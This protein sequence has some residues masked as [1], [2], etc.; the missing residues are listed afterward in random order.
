MENDI[1]LIGE[2]GYDITLSNIIEKVN[3]SD[4]SKPLNIY[5]HSMGGSVYE[6]L[7]IYSYFKSLKQEV[8]TASIGIVASMASV[9]FLSGKKETRKIGEHDSFLIHLPSTFSVG[10]AI[11]LEKDAKELRDIENKISKIY[12]IETNLTQKEALALMKKD[13]MLDVKFLKEKGFVNEIVKF[14][15]VAIYDK[16]KNDK[17]DNKMDE[18]QQ[19]TIKKMDT[20]MDKFSNFFSKSKNKIIQDAKGIEIDF[21]DVKEN[22]TPKNGD[23][24]TIDGKKAEGDVVMPDGS[25]MIFKNGKLTDTKEPE[26][27]QA[28]LTAENKALNEKLEAKTKEFSDFK[29]KSDKTVNDIESEFKQLKSEIKSNFN[30]EGKKKPTDPNTGGKNPEGSR[31]KEF[32]SAFEN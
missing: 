6:G 4:K 29:A 21:P 28:K 25:T 15:A 20:F 31:M 26:D 23:S 18:K 8:N 16:N 1:F 27:I 22:E 12:S 11:D 24:A 9:M 3:N 32:K 7:A 10:N 17:N 30:Y 2:V 14:K 5:F 13:E 19:E